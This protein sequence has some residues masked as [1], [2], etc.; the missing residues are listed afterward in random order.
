MR[1]GK[2]SHN[3]LAKLLSR[4]AEVKKRAV[5]VGPRL[6]EDAAVVR[7]GGRLLVIAT[8]PVTFATD[9]VGWYAV[10]INAN[11][12]ATM[13]AEPAWFQAC[14]LVP[15]GKRVQVDR[16]FADIDTACTELEVAVTGGHTEV[17]ADIRHPIVVGTMFGVADRSR[18]VVSSGLRSG[19]DI[20]MT[21][22]AAIEATA[23]LAR[24]FVDRIQGK[25]PRRLLARSK[26]FLFDPG[27]SVVRQALLAADWGA[28]AMHDPT[29]GGIITGLWELAQA[30]GKRLVVDKSMIPVRE[31][32][33]LLC[34]FF[35]IDPLRAIASGSL[36]IGIPPSKTYSLLKK[37]AQ[38][39]IAATR[40]G[41][42][43]A[44]PPEVS[45][46]SGKQL[47]PRTRDE[48]ARIQSDYSP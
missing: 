10:Q 2:L 26:S 45:D 41:E 33:L 18:P 20:V 16:I 36:L 1:P 37:M 32:T 21:G 34:R 17:T 44:G 13:G 42:C 14:I 19:N 15:A 5:I 7:L 39:H 12:V 11:D 43:V 23:I 48:I 6:G 4:L 24:D 46:V 40:I 27:I 25:V 35:G 30:S 28:T 47:K 22:F 29:E 9:R 3:V 31:E 38:N 8:D